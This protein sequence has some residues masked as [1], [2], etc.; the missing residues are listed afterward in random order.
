MAE[1]DN[2]RGHVLV[3]GALL[4]SAALSLVLALV[5]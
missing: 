2:P 1:C 3:A 5:I 4:L